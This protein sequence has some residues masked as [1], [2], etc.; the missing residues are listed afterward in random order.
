MTARPLR[1]G[2]CG[3]AYWAETV[4]LPALQEADGLS[5]VA[6]YGRSADRRAS[7]AR[8]F[9][10]TPFGEF[11]AFLEEVDAVSFAVP[12]DVQPELAE[13]ALAAG[14]AIIVEK[15]VARS[16]ERANGLF[17][18]AKA[19]RS[20]V[21]C[22]LTRRYIPQTAMV[23]EQASASSASGGRSYFCSAAQSS[24]DPYA[25][26]QWRKEPDALL[27]DVGPHALTP[28]VAALGPIVSVDVY[29]ET[30]S[31]CVLD[32]SHESGV[33][34]R[35]EVAQGGPQSV[36]VEEYEFTTPDGLL[37]IT[38]QPYDRVAAFRLACAELLDLVKADQG[39][40]ECFA[41]AIHFTAVLAAALE[42]RDTGRPIKIPSAII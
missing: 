28:L 17:T 13:L 14:K 9:G 24:S 12:P 7:L 21:V 29:R 38:G 4:H 8:N 41:A 37:K 16:I 3:T 25:N 10:I 22:F 39:P 40:G 35:V 19:R 34:S 36:M 27:W 23:A 15:P 1:F 32:V 31:G 18:L 11:A 26:S 20:P 30:S 6:V 42:C 5:L 2:V 33:R